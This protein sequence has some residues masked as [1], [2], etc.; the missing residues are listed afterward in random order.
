MWFTIAVT[1]TSGR[2]E[3]RTMP[4]ASVT[5]AERYAAEVSKSPE[6]SHVSVTQEPFEGVRS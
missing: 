2:Q 3:I 6:V 4:A 1:H 5:E